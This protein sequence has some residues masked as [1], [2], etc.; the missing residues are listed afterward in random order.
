[1]HAAFEDVLKYSF[2]SS[3]QNRISGNIF[4][5]GR[6]FT[7]PREMN[8]KIYSV[9]SPDC[10]VPVSNAF[11][12]FKYVDENRSAGTAYKGDYR[13]F[14]MGFPFETI[15]TDAHRA[16]IMAGILQFLNGR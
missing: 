2:E 9:P 13:T 16:E 14:I 11:P 15:D 12:V 4:G 8:E 7:I 5:L 3:V 1:M 10:I 6:A